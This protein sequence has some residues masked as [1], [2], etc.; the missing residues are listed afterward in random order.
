MP[1]VCCYFNVLTSLCTGLSPTVNY[2]WSQ[3]HSRTKTIRQIP[4]CIVPL[5]S[6]KHSLP[7]PATASL[8]P[9]SY[10]SGFEPWQILT[11]FCCWP[12]ASPMSD[13]PTHRLNVRSKFRV[14]RLNS[15]NSGWIGQCV[16][17]YT[18]CTATWT[19]LLGVW[20]RGKE[21]CARSSSCWLQVQT[22]AIWRSWT[23]MTR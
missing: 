9:V 12:K 16:T 13:L 21:L 11:R 22:E 14:V 19:L 4:S 15:H 18:V 8:R 6:Q 3:S 20:R 2:R 7:H 23:A 1:S 17:V 10:G 5:R